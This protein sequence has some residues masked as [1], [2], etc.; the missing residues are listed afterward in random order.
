MASQAVVERPQRVENPEDGCTMSVLQYH[1]RVTQGGLG[2]GNAIKPMA[3]S[4]VIIF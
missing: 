2:V 3:I 4:I 1:L